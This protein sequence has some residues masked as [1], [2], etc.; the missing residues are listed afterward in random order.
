MRI[1]TSRSQMIICKE[2]SIWGNHSQK[3]RKTQILPHLKFF[4]KT[5]LLLN[6]TFM[7]TPRHRNNMEKW[8]TQGECLVIIE[9]DWKGASQQTLRIAGHHSKLRKGKGSSPGIFRESKASLT[10]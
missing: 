3:E 6:L 1:V 5:V 2:L 10:P 7:K 9:S 4:T 8:M